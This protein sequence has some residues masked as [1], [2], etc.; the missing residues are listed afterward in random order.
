M[1]DNYVKGEN[2]EKKRSEKNIETIS[3]SKGGRFSW[4]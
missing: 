1:E 2:H 3:H 4:I